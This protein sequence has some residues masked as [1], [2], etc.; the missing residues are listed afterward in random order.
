LS[1]FKIFVKVIPKYRLNRQ[2]KNEQIRK[3]SKEGIW[4]YFW[5]SYREKEMLLG[6]ERFY[7]IRFFFLFFFFCG[8]RIWTQGLYLEWLTCPFLWRVF[9]DRVLQTISVG[10]LWILILLISASWVA[11]IIGMSHRCLVIRVFFFLKDC[12]KMKK[13]TGKTPNVWKSCKM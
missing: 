2:K 3:I 10:W 1:K 7:K 8:T 13:D 12:S 9:Q 6:E 5:K 4:T 11:R